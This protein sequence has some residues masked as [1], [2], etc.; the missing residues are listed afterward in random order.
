MKLLLENWRQYLK[1]DESRQATAYIDNI[2][3]KSHAS[4]RKIPD[5]FE[6]ITE[7]N[8]QITPVAIVNELTPSYLR[9]FLEKYNDENTL[10]EAVIDVAK[11]ADPREIAVINSI[12]LFTAG[13]VAAVRS[14]EEYSDDM[15]DTLASPV[16]GQGYGDAKYVDSRLGPE[17]VLEPTQMYKDRV[18]SGI[19][20]P[21]Y[22][23]KPS[24]E[25]YTIAN[26]VMSQLG[27]LKNVNNPEVIYRGMGL[28][29][30]VIDNLTEGAIFNNKS[31]SS[32]TIS[33]EVAQA[34]DKF[35][36][37]AG[38]YVQFIIESPP[39]GTD[40][41]NLSAFPQEKEFI[42]GKQVR[43]TNVRKKDR[44]SMGM[45][46]WTYITCEIV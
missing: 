44:T 37:G 36:M 32:W 46:I 38:E 3:S 26:Y 19:K 1:E 31:V 7:D 33:R 14:P 39:I 4:G 16:Q 21:Q 40:I 12:L 5:V 41:S 35:S 25:L 9:T 42:L 27:V 30:E 43:I 20:V 34:M 24:K 10:D 45:G 8:E 13:N 11:I 18:K 29:V 22:L 17:D 23:L 15:G 2:F 6:K 28:P